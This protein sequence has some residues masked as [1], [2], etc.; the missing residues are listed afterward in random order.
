MEKKEENNKSKHEEKEV[1]MN[2][3]ENNEIVKSNKSSER[4]KDINSNK[5]EIKSNVQNN[6]EKSLTEKNSQNKEIHEKDISDNNLVNKINNSNDENDDLTNIKYV[7]EKQLDQLNQEKSEKEKYLLHN[8]NTLIT[9]KDLQQ[10]P[11]KKMI[12]NSPRSLKALYDSG[13][14]LDQLYH[15]TLDEFV[16]EHKELLHIEEEAKISRYHFFE[17]LRMDKINTLVDY[18]EKMILDELDYMNN[19]NKNNIQEDENKIKPMKGIIL[20][21][22]KR[23]AQE[24]IDIMQKKHEK[25]LANLIQIE[26]DK[27]LFNLEMKK[28]QED[29]EKKYQKLNFLN[30]R[31]ATQ[32]ND[33]KEEEPSEEQK[34]LSQIPLSEKGGMYFITKNVQK[35][36]KS[37]SLPKKPR[38]LVDS[39]NNYLDNLY[40][41]QQTLMN[42]KY[43]KKQKIVEQKLERL[44]KIRKITGEQRA[45]KKRIGVERAAQNLQ[46]NAIDFNKKH[47]DLIKEIQDKKIIIYQNKKKFENIIKNKNEWNNIKYLV[48][49][50]LIE[51][52]KRKDENLRLLK[53]AELLEKQ[54]KTDIIKNERNNVLEN[55]LLK[56]EY[57]DNERKKNIIKINQIL[58]NGINEEN[59]DRLIK[60]FPQNQELLKIIRNY[61][62]NKNTLLS[63]ELKNFNEKKVKTRRP[64]SQ[65]K[66]FL[67]LINK[68]TTKNSD[69]INKKKEL[70]S[71]TIPNIFNNDKNEKALTETNKISNES[72]IKEKIKLYKDLHYKKFYEKVQQ[73]R[74]NEEMRLKELEKIEDKNK[75]YQL[76]KKFRKER[77]LVY[78]RLERENQK[79]NEK[80]NMYE[81]KLKNMN[82]KI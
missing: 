45:L 28:Q 46:K 52:L 32:N 16:E 10:N 8:K 29:Y 14:S 81:L 69:D 60:E 70:P 42:Q 82:E 22:D 11:N 13:Y 62:K 58:N 30:F 75:R 2:L 44:E 3:T 4:E 23:I 80:I 36:Y 27:D 35:Y 37:I 77:A 71:L 63:K 33:S 48:K 26:L 12:I 73:E 24:E 76:E 61:K 79:M 41:L 6:L 53:F 43:E 74:E 34:S 78:M 9:I 18:R 1:G 40:N 20:D 38:I 5:E 51:D 7:T 66:L 19:Y 72:D 25:E 59:L 67:N 65:G 17:K 21:N 68:N 56:K 55:K 49:M 15:K 47:E 54:S 31:T 39:N 57:L 50:D 64:K